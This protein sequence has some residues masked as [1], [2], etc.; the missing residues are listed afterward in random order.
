MKT[1]RELKKILHEARLT[2]EYKK[3]KSHL[4]RVM[5]NKKKAPKG[6]YACKINP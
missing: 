5:E 1:Q 2:E 6:N 4:D 3:E